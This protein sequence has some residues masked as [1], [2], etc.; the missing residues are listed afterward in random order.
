VAKFSTLFFE[1]KQITI[2]PRDW[3]HYTFVSFGTGR[4]IDSEPITAFNAVSNLLADWLVDFLVA[5]FI[6]SNLGMQGHFPYSV[7]RTAKASS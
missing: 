5:L 6:H 4:K 7:P 3:L 2:Q 1:S